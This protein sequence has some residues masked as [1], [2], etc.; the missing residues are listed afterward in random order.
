MHQDTPRT[1]ADRLLVRT[2]RGIELIAAREVRERLAVS[3]TELGHREVRFRAGLT[4]TLLDL[5]TVDDAFLILREGPPTGPRRAD[6][7][8]LRRAASAVDLGEAVRRL[9]P[10]RSVAGGVFDVSGSFLGHRNYSRYEIEDAV[11]EVLRAGSGRR[12]VSRR[13][14]PPPSTG[15]SIRVHLTSDRTTI[16]V[17]IAARPLHRRPYRVVSLP[18]ALH[19]PLANALVRIAD[20]PRNAVV[21]DPFCGTGTI[22]IEAQLTLEGSRVNGADIDPAGVAAAHENAAAAGV[23]IGLVIA[24]AGRLPFAAESVDAL[25]TNPPWGARVQLGG[26]LRSGF[27]PFW[28]ELARILRSPAR[29]AVLAGHDIAVP[30]AFA[31]ADRFPLRLAGARAEVLLIDR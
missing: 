29:V 31:I 9:G 7:S 27:T 22:P 23:A 13:A 15:L 28:S 10:I 21:L 3:C 26:V 16:A 11:G 5:R 25:V 17:R 30:P 2:V 18:G 12:Y 4:P 1:G 14:E 6:L 19:P 24:D 20:P 8:R